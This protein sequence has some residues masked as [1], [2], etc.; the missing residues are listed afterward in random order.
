LDTIIYWLIV[1]LA[2]PCS[3]AS[4]SDVTSG[5]NDLTSKVTAVVNLWNALPDG[6][7]ALTDF[8]NFMSGGQTVMTI[9]GQITSNVQSLSAAQL[10]PAA[11]G[12]LSQLQVIEPQIASFLIA[13]VTKKPAF[14]SLPASGRIISTVLTSVNM[15]TTSFEKAFLRKAPA[16]IVSAAQNLQKDLDSAF[17]KAMQAYKA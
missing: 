13:T 4:V 10:A 2:I 3:C 14:S 1:I 17:G 15:T 7:V 12:I 6:P 8:A 9:I 5:I 16:N 11:P